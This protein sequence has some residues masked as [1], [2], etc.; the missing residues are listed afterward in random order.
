MFDFFFTGS[1]AIKHSNH[2][3]IAIQSIILFSMECPHS[4]PYRNS[5]IPHSVR[6][7]FT[8]FFLATFTAWKL[9][10]IS[11]ISSAAKPATTNIHQSIGIR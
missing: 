1:L 6:N 11:A 10:V 4:E 2:L 3:T 5:V 9:I 8:G 7:D